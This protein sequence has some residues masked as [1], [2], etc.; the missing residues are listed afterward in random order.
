[1]TSHVAFIGQIPGR[2]FCPFTNCETEKMLINI[3]HIDYRSGKS[4]IPSFWGP[5]QKP[6]VTATVMKLV[7][8]VLKLR[9]TGFFL[10]K[11]AESKLLIPRKL[12]TC[13]KCSTFN[14]T[15]SVW[16]G[17]RHQVNDTSLGRFGKI[18]PDFLPTKR[19]RYIIYYIYIY[20]YTFETNK[21]T[22]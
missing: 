6:T 11:W 2:F 7:Y 17:G 3:R 5:G 9:S 8:M 13:P 22:C 15:S 12:S 4:P 10:W 14:R 21:N 1:M 16:G 20:K 18:I 19:V